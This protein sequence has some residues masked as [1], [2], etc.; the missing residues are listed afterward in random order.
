[1][2]L[3]DTV[4]APPRWSFPKDAGAALPSDPWS[5][6]PKAERAFRFDDWSA[7]PFVGD[8]P[9]FGSEVADAVFH[10]GLI[11][12]IDFPSVVDQI[13][14]LPP[15]AATPDLK[16]RVGME[17]NDRLSYEACGR[18]QGALGTC[19]ANAVATALDIAARRQAPAYPGRFSAAWLHVETGDDRRAG[20]DLADVIR[21]V[22]HGLLCQDTTFEYP[23]TPEALQRWADSTDAPTRETVAEDDRQIRQSHGV[24]EV[25]PLRRY[26]EEWDIPSIKA[27]LAAGWVVVVGT[28]VPDEVLRSPGLRHYDAMVCP[29][30]GS[31]RQPGGHAWCLVGYDHVDGNQQW[32]YQGRFFALNT[33]GPNAPVRGTF[34]KGIGTMPFAFL[35]TEGLEAFAVRFHRRAVA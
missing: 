12:P 30:Y 19:V 14:V 10:G 32:K 25:Q 24:L 28:A 9:R 1:M 21:F 22:R 15:W 17:D 3:P 13:R 2:G 11:L 8:Q 33:W 6:L 20:R 5:L 31:P 35:L 16:L 4:D 27:H 29:T 18:D 26:G 7:S 34:G 23:T